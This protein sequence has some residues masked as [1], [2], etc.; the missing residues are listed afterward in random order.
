[1]QFQFHWMNTSQT[2]TFRNYEVFRAATCYE[3]SNK[4][5]PFQSEECKCILKRTFVTEAIKV[6]NSSVKAS[7]K[8]F[9]S[10][11]FSLIT[12]SYAIQFQLAQ[13]LG[14]S[15]Q[16]H[17]SSEGPF[18][19]HYLDGGI[20]RAPI[21]SH[22]SKGCPN[23]ATFSSKAPIFQQISTFKIEEIAPITR[24]NAYKRGF[25]FVRAA[26]Q[27]IPRLCQFLEEAPDV[28]DFVDPQ[29]GYPDFTAKR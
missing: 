9:M 27:G 8:P 21:F 3:H 1:M 23:A 25:C 24:Y 28:V 16:T 4:F 13:N 29:R 20:Q 6:T 17:I 26:M 7:H 12:F 18:R 2:D 15:L 14:L 22:L 11:C 19:K 10:Q 5:S